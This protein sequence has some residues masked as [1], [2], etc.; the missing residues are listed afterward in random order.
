MLT[1]QDLVNDL[2]KGCK[3]RAKWRIGLEHERFAFIRSSGAP[4]TFEG[5]AGIEALLSHF[6]KSQSWTEKRENGHLIALEKNGCNLTLEPG[7][8]VEFSGT[9]CAS[10]AEAQAEMADFNAK[11]DQSATAL[12]IDFMARGI[13]PDWAR[14]DIQAMPKARYAIMSAYMP[15]KGQLGLDMMFRTAGA[16]VNLDFESEEDMVKKYRIA[17]ALQPLITALMANSRMVDGK[18]SEYESFRAQIWT[19]T[20]PDRCGIPAFVFDADMSF[21]RYVDYAL[22]VPMYFYRRHGKYINTAGLS[23]RDFMAGKLPGHEGIFPDIHDWQDH[24]TTLFPEVRLKRYLELR[25]ADSNP[26]DHVM[27]MAGFWVGILYDADTV[28]VLHDRIKD[29]PLSRH[30]KLLEDVARY[31][32]AA[33]IEDGP[34]LAVFAGEILEIAQQGLDTA[35][36]TTAWLAPFFHRLNA[37]K[38]KMDTGQQHQTG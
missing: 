6:A 10:L 27:A 20:D 32:L 36:E 17:L 29:W 19:D 14:A 22:D 33:V 1:Y 5:R 8:Q 37:H 34:P 13:P 9:P 23:F 3:P 16:Q 18:D 15:K 25:N 4:L 7:G 12:G 26:A 11:L 38:M 30:Q 31:G 28:T 24:L 35:G 2:Q 21:A